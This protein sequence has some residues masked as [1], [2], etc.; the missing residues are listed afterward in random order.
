MDNT[1]QRLASGAVTNYQ[2][3]LNPQF[4]HDAASGLNERLAHSTAGLSHGRLRVRRTAD[5][6]SDAYG[7]QLL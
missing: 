3:S 6:D 5:Y 7:I 4:T 2:R 1:S